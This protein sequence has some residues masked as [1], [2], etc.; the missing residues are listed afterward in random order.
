M[1]SAVLVLAFSVP[2]TAD[3]GFFYPAPKFFR[4]LIFKFM[5]V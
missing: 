5:E 3:C 1:F 4:E 2:G